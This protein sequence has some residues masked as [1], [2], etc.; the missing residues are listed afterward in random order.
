MLVLFLFNIWRMIFKKLS[1]AFRFNPSKWVSS[2]MSEIM[3]K[4]NYSFAL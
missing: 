4:R 3:N 1:E 2:N